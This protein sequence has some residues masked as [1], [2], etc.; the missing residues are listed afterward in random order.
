MENTNPKQRRRFTA[1]FKLNVIQ[2]AKEKGNR[3]AGREYGIDASVIRRW[4]ANEEKLKSLPK[5][6]KANR[7]RKSRHPQLERDVVTCIKSLRE[8]ARAVSTVQAWTK[9]L[10]LTKVCKIGDFASCNLVL[11]D[12]MTQRWIHAVNTGVCFIELHKMLSGNTCL[13]VFWLHPLPLFYSSQLSPK[14][15]HT[16]STSHTWPFSAIAELVGESTVK[17][18][19]SSCNIYW[20][21]LMHSLIWNTHFESCVLCEI[22]ETLIPCSRPL[23]LNVKLWIYFFKE[24]IGQA[25]ALCS[26]FVRLRIPALL[27]LLA[28]IFHSVLEHSNE[29]STQI[30]H[31]LPC[32]GRREVVMCP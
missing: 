31:L 13:F 16:N 7:G 9:A 12:P 8:S 32:N 19:P 1:G 25:K 2:L 6:K 3:A 11:R 27:L 10:D 22:S 5:G 21:L 18:F 30:F 20:L 17:V 28:L 4:R 23:L 15:L 29:T 24:L 14:F 26:F